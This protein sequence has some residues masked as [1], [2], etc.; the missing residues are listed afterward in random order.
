MEPKD[1]IVVGKVHKPHGVKGLLK[2]SFDNPFLLLKGLP[3]TAVFINKGG[4]P[5]PYFVS[6][7]EEQGDGQCLL[8]LEDVDSRE[9]AL[10]LNNKE[11]LLP[12][13]V[14][15]QVFDM[16]EEGEFV[17]LEGFTLFDQHN[18]AIGRI[19]EVVVLPGHEL[20]KLTIKGQEVLIPL[21]EE[22]VLAIDE[23]LMTVQVDIPEGLLDLNVD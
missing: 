13:A 22:I 21:N 15:E 19:E 20:A 23:D 2:V 14:A 8:L 4:K 18:Q 6:S 11:I 16:D 7:F 10:A 12:Q 17:D 3:F 9:K 1:L 5:F